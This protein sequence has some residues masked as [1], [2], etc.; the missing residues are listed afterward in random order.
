[1]TQDRTS[2]NSRRLEAANPETPAERLETLARDSQ[3]ALLV[4][5]NP[6]A[7]AE[8]LKQLAQGKD[9]D[10]RAAVV[11]NPNAPWDTIL[12]LAGTFPEAFMANPAI[13][14]LLVE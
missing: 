1:M 2:N 8:L 5:A 11:A 6:A 9:Q 10:V 3:L 14:L 12:G 7:P 13:P 4:A